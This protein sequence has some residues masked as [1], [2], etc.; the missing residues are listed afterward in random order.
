MSTIQSKVVHRNRRNYR[1]NIERYESAYQVAEDCKSRER[2]DSS[3]HDYSTESLRDWHGV[4]TYN[5]ALTLLRDG[6]QPI[7]EQLK[8]E[9]K[10]STTQKRIRIFNDVVGFAPVVPL[11]MMGVPNNMINMRMA[12]IKAKVLDIYYDMTAPASTS[13]QS[14][15]DAGR[16]VLASIVQLEQQGYRFNLYAVQAYCDSSSAD[17]L[18][19]KVKDSAKPLDLKRISFPLA[20]TAFFRVIGFDWY[21][22]FPKGKYRPAYGHA[23]A[24]EFDSKQEL[25]SA[26]KQVLGD[27]AIYISC[28]TAISSDTDNIKEAIINGND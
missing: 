9:L 19:V 20:H 7:V 14:I 23:L 4:K 22:K 15:I 6:Y 2:T 13:P 17:M 8:T 24:Y 27:T 11:A 25:T 18:I 1:F 5:E 3:F 10:V 26:M 16:K 21:S 12:P 28:A